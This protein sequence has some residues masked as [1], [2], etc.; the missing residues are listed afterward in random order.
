MSRRQSL[1][2]RNLQSEIRNMTPIQDVL[3][4]LSSAASSRAGL[5]SLIPLAQL[6]FDSEA[7]QPVITYW[8]D[9]AAIILPIT[10][11]DIPSFQPFF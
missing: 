3:Q 2:H 8:L 4:R 1:F 5:L 6:G 9:G 7:L 11:Q 10:E